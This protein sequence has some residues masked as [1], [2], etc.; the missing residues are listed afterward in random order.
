M[1][2]NLPLHKNALTYFPDTCFGIFFQ[3]L[4]FCIIMYVFSVPTDGQ[5]ILIFNRAASRR[6]VELQYSVC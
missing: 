4:Y 5:A 2:Y 1:K 6:I 3:I